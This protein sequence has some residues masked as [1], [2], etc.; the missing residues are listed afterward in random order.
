MEKV[1]VKG[2]EYAVVAKAD[3]T[4]TA[5]DGMKIEL[6]AGQQAHFTAQSSTVSAD[7]EFT[8]TA[9][10]N[11]A[12]R[13]LRLRAGGVKIDWD[14]YAHCVTVEDLKAVNADYKNDLTADGEWKWKLPKL[15]DGNL[16]F[17]GATA[18]KKW[19]AALPNVKTVNT[20]FQKCTSL[21]TLELNA[22]FIIIA[23]NMC[24][25]CANLRVFR[26][27]LSKITDGTDCFYFCYHLREFYSELSALQSGYDMFTGTQLDKASALRVLTSIPA[28]DPTQ[29][30]LWIGIHQDFRSD[31]EVLNAIA[32][33]E[34][35]GWTFT[36]SWGGVKGEYATAAANTFAMRQTVYAKLVEKNGK[37]Q[38]DW[39]HYVT[40]PTGYTEFASLEE[41]KEHFNIID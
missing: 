3:T 41:A 31:E 28:H 19:S 21:A 20:M 4:L 25:S 17:D 2:Q 27:D 26:G 39:G 33:A 13:K 34:A 12:A 15:Q 11:R 35:R 7:A 18:L 9:T 32:E 36:L 16:A 5:P 29:R 1:V 37:P 22:P 40:D 6:K 8:I 10:F 24:Q 38:L 30:G 14:K 23:A